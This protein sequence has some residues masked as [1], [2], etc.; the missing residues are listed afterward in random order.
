[1]R[2]HAADASLHYSVCPLVLIVG[3]SEAAR[4]RPTRIVANAGFRIGAT[5]GLEEAP[6]RIALQPSASALW[7][8][9][10]EGAGV[11][12]DAALVSANDNLDGRWGAVVSVI[13]ELIDA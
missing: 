2:T 8:E 9:I 11:D 6:H 10:D 5:L 7:L 1:M 4:Q 13:P 3:S 12:L